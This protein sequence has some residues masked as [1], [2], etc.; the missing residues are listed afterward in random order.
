[1]PQWYYWESLSRSQRWGHERAGKIVIGH[2]HW[3]INSH[4]WMPTLAAGI[5]EAGQPVSRDSHCSHCIARPD[6]NSHYWQS[7]PD[8]AIEI[9]TRYHIVYCDTTPNREAG[10]TAWY[11]FITIVSLHCRLSSHCIYCIVLDRIFRRLQLLRP[12]VIENIT[13]IAIDSHCIVFHTEYDNNRHTLC[14]L[15]IL[16]IA[17]TRLVDWRWHCI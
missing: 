6:G 5:A 4:W 2:W 12:I 16:N 14:L 17:I 7:Q 8:I 1:M 11:C 15:Q 13:N 3:L 9:Y 10:L